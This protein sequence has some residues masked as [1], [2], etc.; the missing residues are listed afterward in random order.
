MAKN[1]RTTVSIKPIKETIITLKLVGDS[2]L[3]LHKKSR[4]Y[5]QSEVWKQNHPKGSEM[6]EKYQGKNKWEQFITTINWKDPIEFHDDDPS[7][8]TEEEWNYYMAN[9]QP[10]ILTQAFSKS[11]QEAF[12]SFGYK[13]STKKAG[14]DFQRA[15]NFDGAKVPIT[16]VK[17]TT[18]SKLVP[19]TGIN[20]T[21][22]VY[23][24]NLFS[25]WG[26]TITMS[27]P[28]KVFPVDT[29]VSIVQTA[30]KY[31]GIG[32]QRKNGYGRYHVEGAET[33][34]L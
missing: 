29:V 27:M 20:K 30:G 22:V 4:M 5:E 28:D 6:P 17:A 19:N 25:G 15:L 14:T 23:N 16:F 31:I 18:E 13:D 10:C 8:Y 21:N 11:F 32:S 12:K 24:G 2:D 1:T 7:L 9:N 26:T 34:K 33:F 3:I